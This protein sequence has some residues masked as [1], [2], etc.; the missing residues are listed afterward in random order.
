MKQQIIK[1]NE[2]FGNGLEHNF[3]KHVNRFFT[4]KN[5]YLVIINFSHKHILIT[6]I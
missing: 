1:Q 3:A 2:N 4:Y 6:K 5:N